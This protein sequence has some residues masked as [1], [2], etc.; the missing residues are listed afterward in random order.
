M[1]ELVLT[2]SGGL[3]Q[4]K[5]IY[6]TAPQQLPIP[7]NCFLQTGRRVLAGP[8]APGSKKRTETGDGGCSSVGEYLAEHQQGSGVPSPRT[9]HNKL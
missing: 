1:N 9:S 7:V 5:A 2:D 6:T 4:P 3:S 8:Q